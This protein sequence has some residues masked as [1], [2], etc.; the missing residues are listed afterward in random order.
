MKKVLQ[1]NNFGPINNSLEIDLSKRINIII[2]KQSIGKSTI[3]KLAYFCQNAPGMLLNVVYTVKDRT[4]I[5]N[6]NYFVNKYTKILEREFLDIFNSIQICRDTLIKYYYNE[7]GYILINYSEDKGINILFS[8]DIEYA[9]R[10]IYNEFI[11]EIQILRK[12]NNIN[13]SALIIHTCD[14]YLIKFLNVMDENGTIY[15]PAS[16]AM[17]SF[18]LSVFNENVINTMDRSYLR[19]LNLAAATR[20]DCLDPDELRDKINSFNVKSLTVDDFDLIQELY[21][22][23]LQAKYVFKDNRDLLITKENKEM[24]ARNGSSGQQEILW[25]LNIIRDFILKNVR[26]CF[27][28]EEPETNLFPS[29]Q[30]DA[31]KYIIAASNIGKNDVII[32]THS[33]YILTSANMMLYAGAN[34]T[35]AKN[36]VEEQCLMDPN[37][38]NCFYLDEN[39]CH[40]IYKNGE[41]DVDIIDSISN[42]IYDGIN[43]IMD[44]KLLEG[45]IEDAL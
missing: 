12:I 1:I 42:I 14:K 43:S 7:E 33:P 24:I 39:G 6:E 45:E 25:L 44:K 30:F 38:F 11:N 22:K 19:Y 18:F 21:E 36:V 8:E 26:A 28:I 37:D 31:L 5:L 20:R 2:G 17:T 32:T 13:T 35:Y 41:I 27:A 16:R 4:E 29:T 34:K 15:I 10:N 23:V 40:T 3:V 9:L